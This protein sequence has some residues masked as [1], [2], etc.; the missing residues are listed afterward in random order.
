[1]RGYSPALGGA[2]RSHRV[3][4]VGSFLYMPAAEGRGSLLRVVEFYDGAP[5]PTEQMMPGSDGSAPRVMCCIL[6]YF[7]SPTERRRCVPPLI[8]IKAHL[9]ALCT[10]SYIYYLY[11]VLYMVPTSRT[12]THNCG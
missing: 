4:T 11:M 12:V 9:R 3:L 1:M 6:S 5:T 2:E 7:D 8:Y 10:P